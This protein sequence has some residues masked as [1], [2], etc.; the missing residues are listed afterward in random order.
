MIKKKKKQETFFLHS[1]RRIIDRSEG[2]LGAFIICVLEYYVVYILWCHANPN[3]PLKDT[4]LAYCYI[5][6]NITNIFL[7][8]FRPCN[9]MRYDRWRRRW[10]VIESFWIVFFHFF[11]LV[12]LF[13]KTLRIIMQSYGFH[14]QL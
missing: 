10:V 8:P 3:M 4:S 9:V 5:R 11:F 1:L 2:K 13:L 12:C 7:K 14:A 6:T